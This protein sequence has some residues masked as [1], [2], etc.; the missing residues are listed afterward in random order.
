VLC[1]CALEP[2]ARA[3]LCAKPTVEIM[4][5]LMKTVRVATKKE[6]EIEII[7]RCL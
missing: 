3:L 5:S 2:S 4:E 1:N 6:E 7:V